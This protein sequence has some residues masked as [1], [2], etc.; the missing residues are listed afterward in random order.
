MRFSV[1]GPLELATDAGPV[2]IRGK[3]VRALLAVLLMYPGQVVP[4]ERIVD[5]VWLENPPRSAVE[6]VR[7]YVYQLRTLLGTGPDR[8]VLESE[9]GGYRL[10]VE[11]DALD[12]TRFSRLAHE[13][14]RAHSLGQHATASALLGEALELWRGTPLS[15]LD[16][17]RA[18]RAKAVALEEQRWQVYRNW[19][20]ARLALG[21]AG[22]LV[23]PLRELVGE[24]PLD[25]SLWCLLVSALVLTGRT[26]EALAAFDEAR[27]TL[28]QEL[29]IEPGPQ[30]RELQARVLRGEGLIDPAPVAA[31]VPGSGPAAPHQLPAE[32][33][34]LVGRAASLRAVEALA[35]RS[36]S[37]AVDQVR[38]VLV[39][40]PPGV[41]KTALAITAAELVHSHVPDGELYVDLRGATENPL[42]P[43][44]AMATLL[45]A[46]AIAPNAMPDSVDGRRSLYRSILAE[47]TMLVLLDDAASAQQVLP[48]LPGPGRS[49]VLV[50]SRRC[51]TGVQADLRIALDPLT[52]QE[53]LEML[54]NLIGRDRID[55]E[56]ADSAAIVE[57][58]GGLPSA[59]G[60]A[61][62]RL[63]NRPNHPVKVLADCLE[64]GDHLLDEFSF[65]GASLRAEFA[66]SYE[67]LE[68]QARRCFRA[69]ALLPA[70]AIT[71]EGIGAAIGVSRHAADRELEGLVREGLLMTDVT[72]NGSPTYTMPTVLHRF[73]HERLE[74]E[75]LRM[76]LVAQPEIA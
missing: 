75:G 35:Q 73:A 22:E 31:G 60:I 18:M 65:D 49:L 2:H 4:I 13:G 29:G 10:V 27:R 7:T 59:I 15:G 39:S 62:A 58:C 9:P 68:P 51:L 71:A 26:G 12:V 46:L 76:A 6:N 56:P 43:A 19:M 14:R 67:A 28:V 24:R 21:Q 47:R 11:P 20:S 50:V 69:L 30:L 17:G 32:L 64:P 16:L 38:T 42:E 1:L 34:R 23:A 72:L 25:E 44:E 54:A 45:G 5:D 37:G 8:P 61:G 66:N 57:A 41:G 70:H 33:P 48:L 3:R 63:S 36:G 52:T 40:G 74:L 53:S 55:H